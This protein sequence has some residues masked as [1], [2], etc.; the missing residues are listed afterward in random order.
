MESITSK[1]CL[2]L[3]AVVSQG[4]GP[5]GIWT[6]AGLRDGV[7]RVIAPRKFGYEG[8]SLSGANRDR[9]SAR[10][11]QAATSAISL[12]Q[13]SNVVFNGFAGIRSWSPPV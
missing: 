10:S 4:A 8:T 7:A 13:T 12:L 3:R 6:V 9:T 11:S 5:A 2:P 1:T